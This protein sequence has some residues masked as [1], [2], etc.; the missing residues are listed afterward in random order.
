MTS[1]TIAGLDQAE[2]LQLA[3]HASST[4]DSGTALSYL[5]EAV[6][7]TDATAT[8]HFL[9]GA[10]YAQIRMVDRAVS[11]MESAIALDPSLSIARFQLGLLL[12]TSGDAARAADVLQPLQEL[13]IQHAL[14]HFGNG[15]LHLIRDE[16]AETTQCLK[17]G[18]ELNTE[19][20]ALNADMQKIMEQ[21]KLLPSDA[22]ANK[23][24]GSVSENADA[25]HIFIS[26]YTGN[27][28]N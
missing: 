19:N 23:D 11:E 28:N 21:I 16:F 3:L 5:K 6:T 4:G 1:A 8:A 2:L 20:Q 12:L 25:R 14:A 13:G 15:L 18:I 26:A 7:R 24:G 17:R 9:L 27:G 22:L 10:E